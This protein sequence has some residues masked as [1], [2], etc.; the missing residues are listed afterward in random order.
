MTK[1]QE[2]LFCDIVSLTNQRNT[3]RIKINSSRV[4]FKYS[5]FLKITLKAENFNFG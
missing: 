5:L 1:H 3:G 2:Y 4:A